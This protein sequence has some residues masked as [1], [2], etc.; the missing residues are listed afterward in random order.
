MNPSNE[1]IHD[2]IELARA[3]GIDISLIDANL[4]LTV[5]QRVAQHQMALDMMLALESAGKKLRE[6]MP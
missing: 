4:R 3:A 6:P 1:P 2:P 5:E